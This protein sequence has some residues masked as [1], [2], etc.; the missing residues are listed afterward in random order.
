[1]T[2]VPEAIPNI[3]RPH[4][5]RIDLDHLPRVPAHSLPL[6]MHRLSGPKED[7]PTGTWFRIDSF[8]CVDPG[9][10]RVTGMIVDKV[11][12]DGNTNVPDHN[13]VG[14]AALNT[15]VPVRENLHKEDMLHST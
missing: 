7:L 8:S 5:D 3:R 14:R 15:S 4:R 12:K 10:P 2:T 11:S 9:R 13:C 1:M 6:R